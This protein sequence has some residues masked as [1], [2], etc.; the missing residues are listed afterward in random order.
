[1]Y[2]RRDRQRETAE[3]KRSRARRDREREGIRSI[4]GGVTQCKMSRARRDEVRGN[5]GNWRVMR[6]Q[7]KE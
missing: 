2:G 5:T 4:H 6:K 1:V 7:G 3:R